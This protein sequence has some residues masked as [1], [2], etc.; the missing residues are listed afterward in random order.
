MNNMIDTLYSE[1]DFPEDAPYENGNYENICCNCGKH[2]LG[3]KH[4]VICK[5]CDHPV[6][7]TSPAEQFV[8]AFRKFVQEHEEMFYH[9]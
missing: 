7:E 6:E 3:N 9:E 2:F 1:R 5:L 8:E 4:R